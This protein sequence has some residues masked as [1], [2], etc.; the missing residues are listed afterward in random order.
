MMMMMMDL[1]A[2]ADADAEGAVQ[3]G[4]IESSCLQLGCLRDRRR[5]CLTGLT[6]LSLFG[7]RFVVTLLAVPAVNQTTLRHSDRS[8]PFWQGPR[9]LASF[10]TME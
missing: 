1:G 6:V 2:D 5:A 7:K 8:W 10:N 4:A 9:V 3:A